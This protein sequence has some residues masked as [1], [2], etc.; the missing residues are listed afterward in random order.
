MQIAIVALEGS[1]LSAISGLADMFWICNQASRNPPPGVVTA[2]A[3]S[4]SPL[5]HTRIV[6][7]DG[8]PLRDPQGRWIPVDGAFDADTAYDAILIAGMALGPDGQPPH[9]AAHA[10]AACWLSSRHQTGVLIGARVPVPL[11]WAKPV[12]S[13]DAVA[14]PP[15]G[16]TMCSS[17]AFRLPAM[18]GAAP[19]RSKTAS[20]PPE[21]HCPGWTWPCMSSADWRP[22][23]G[24][25]GGGHF[26]GR[27]PAPAAIAVCPAWLRQHRQS[28]VIAGR[29]NHPP[30]PPR[31]DGGGPGSGITPER[32]HLAPPPEATDRRVTQGLHHPRAYRN[33]VCVAGYARHQHQAGGRPVW[34]WR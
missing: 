31:N 24:Q 15:G 2:L 14:P 7:A 22:G 12:C 25:A 29:A 20:L 21:G 19:W 26:G 27:Q 32:A 9:S 13:T 11:C 16:Y 6:S 4:P 30:C 34:L 10:Q 8:Q 17:S 1:L 3:G 33:S 28:S 18:Y 23:A 5:F